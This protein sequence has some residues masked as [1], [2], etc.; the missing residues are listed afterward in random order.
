MDKLFVISRKN[1]RWGLP[2]QTTIVY[3]L[4]I[5]R[6]Q[7]SEIWWGVFYAF[8]GLI[9]LASLH[10]MICQEEVDIFAGKK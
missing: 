3:W 1:Y 10:N 9:W 6:I 8:I 7:P 5:D 4:L 2:I